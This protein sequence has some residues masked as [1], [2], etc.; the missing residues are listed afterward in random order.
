MRLSEACLGAPD[1]GA[2]VCGVHPSGGGFIGG[3]QVGVQKSSH[4][5]KVKGSGSP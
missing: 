4:R 2:L 1:V 5:Y 3:G